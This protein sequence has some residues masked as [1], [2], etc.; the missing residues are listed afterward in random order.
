MVLFL[1]LN[2]RTMVIAKLRFIL[3]LAIASP[4]SGDTD[5]LL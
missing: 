2:E 4:V 1:D 3:S 5:K